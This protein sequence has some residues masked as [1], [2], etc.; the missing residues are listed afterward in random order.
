MQR[1]Y[2]NGINNIGVHESDVE[3]KRADYQEARRLYEGLLCFNPDDERLLSSLGGALD[4]LVKVV[5][6]KDKISAK[7]YKIG[8][9]F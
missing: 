8:N 7:G 6:F 4:N 9:G 5:L 2:V 3:S 1:C